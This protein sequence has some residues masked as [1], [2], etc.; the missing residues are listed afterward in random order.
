[1]GGGEPATPWKSMDEN[2]LSFCRRWYASIM[3]TVPDLLRITIDCVS[4]P[5]AE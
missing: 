2:S 4:A 5:P 3:R 1:M